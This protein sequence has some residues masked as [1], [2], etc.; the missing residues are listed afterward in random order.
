MVENKFS[1]LRP[2]YLKN[3]ESDRRATMVSNFAE[4]Q[5]KKILSSFAVKR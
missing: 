4:V 1:G 5:L 2:F 3:K